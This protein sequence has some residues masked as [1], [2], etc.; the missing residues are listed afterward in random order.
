[1]VCC[2]KHLFCPPL[3]DD[4]D[5]DLEL[6]ERIRSLRWVTTQHLKCPLDESHRAVTD[7]LCDAMNGEWLQNIF[8]FPPLTQVLLHGLQIFL[9][10][11]AK[12]R[13]KTNSTASSRAP[14]KFSRCSSCPT[15][16]QPRPMI[17]YPA[18]FTFASRP[19]RPG[20]SPT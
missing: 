14:K 7:L 16:T 19:T 9:Q 11:T 5:K 18:S 17:F 2:H 6:Q 20:S 13:R 1:M 10:W 8:F 15:T 4:E 3:G 12:W